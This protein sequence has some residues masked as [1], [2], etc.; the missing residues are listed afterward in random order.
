METNG[1]G[2]ELIMQEVLTQQKAMQELEAENCELRR[3]LADLREG[4]GI[5]IELFGT[6]YALDVKPGVEKPE[7]A[8]TQELVPAVEHQPTTAIEVP[9][10]PLPETS[11]PDP[12]A[13]QAE[14]PDEATLLPSSSF[15]E[16]M[17]LDEFSSV[18][19]SPMAVW[20]G[21]SKK[22]TPI[23]DED[24]ATLRREL[25]DSFLLE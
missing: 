10:T 23:N 12:D 20:S 17:L 16:E 25:V 7:S 15:L 24:K 9:T 21:S 5:F 3:Q 22:S 1:N 8:L 6:R 19:T 4:R 11:L 18:A 2:F 14:T 13:A